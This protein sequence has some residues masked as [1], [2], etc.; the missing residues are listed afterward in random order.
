[1]N[2]LEL[3]ILKHKFYIL[4]S[5]TLK[6]IGFF[7]DYVFGR[8]KEDYPKMG[9]DSDEAKIVFTKDREVWQSNKVADHKEEKI[10]IN[11]NKIEQ[12]TVILQTGSGI[13][14]GGHKAHLAGGFVQDSIAG[15]LILTNRNLTFITYRQYFK[16]FKGVITEEDWRMVIPL[17]NILV[18]KWTVEENSR[19]KTFSGGNIPLA[20]GISHMSGKIEESGKT[21]NLVIPYIDSNGIEQEPRFGVKSFTGKA[22]KKWAETFYNIVAE[23]HKYENQKK[24]EENNQKST[25]ENGKED[26]PMKILKIRFAKGEITKE[27][28]DEMKKALEE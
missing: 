27:E 12:E 2:V 28:Y 17:K 22:I 4:N 20:F 18:E 1:M 26:E 15:E 10:M 5:N 16:P 23:I 6:F 21:H 25:E 7:D 8:K 19:R 24:I 14:Y 3:Y 9:K 11:E 13:Y